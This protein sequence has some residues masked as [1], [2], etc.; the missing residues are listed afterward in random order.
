MHSQNSQI[1]F[2]V[3]LYLLDFCK[4]YRVFACLVRLSSLHPFV[5][6]APRYFHHPA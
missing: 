4:H 6:A 1:V 5:I 3:S 2:V